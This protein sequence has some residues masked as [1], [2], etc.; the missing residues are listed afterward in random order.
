MVR[1]LLRAA[2]IEGGGYRVRSIDWGTGGG[3]QDFL[4]LLGN[5]G[6]CLGPT[7][8][9]RSRTLQLPLRWYYPSIPFRSAPP[10]PPFSTFNGRLST[11]RVASAICILIVPRATF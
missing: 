10:P 2:R 1:V 6:N 3:K 5:G 11:T 7:S 4:T 8:S 9:G